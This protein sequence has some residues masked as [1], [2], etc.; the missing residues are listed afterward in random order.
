MKLRKILVMPLLAASVALAQAA[1]GVTGD[2]VAD[3]WAYGSNSLENGTYVRGD[4]NLGF[5]IHSTGFTLGAGSNLLDANWQVGDTVL[6]I[7]GVINA[8]GSAAQLG[9][10]SITGPTVND[11]LTQSVRI[12]TKFGTSPTAWSASTVAPSA[13]NGSGSFSGG[14][15]GDGSLLL[16]T[17][18]PAANN[19]LHLHPSPDFG[20]MASLLGP[21]IVHEI[22]LLQRY[23]SGV[24]TTLASTAGKL[25]YTLDGNDVLSTWE[26][27]VNVTLLEGYG[28]VPELGDR[29]MQ[30]LQRSTGVYTDGLVGVIPEP[31]TVGLVVLGAAAL[32]RRR[33][34]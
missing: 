14:A 10:P 5:D 18:S 34:S 4:G 26:V 33:R 9:W 30:T 32:L 1:W 11:N 25:I 12:V 21:D 7:G 6:G 22:P 8:I 31:A 17:Y 15:G 13:G 3:G 16:A 27:F 28:I 29:G 23:D 19:G 24:V 20:L 2:P